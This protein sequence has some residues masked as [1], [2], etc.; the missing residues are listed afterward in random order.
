MLISRTVSL[1]ASI[2]M[3]GVTGLSVAACAARTDDVDAVETETE[4][5]AVSSSAQPDAEY[6]IVTHPDMRRCA[7]PMCG[8]YFV[9]AVNADLVTGKNAGLTKCADGSFQK[10]CHVFE[11]GYVSFGQNGRGQAAFDGKL[12]SGAAIARGASTTGSTESGVAFDKLVVRE[13]WA[14]R[15]TTPA[16]GS[17]ATLTLPDVVCQSLSCA[18]G[19]RDLVDNASGPTAIQKI[20]WAAGFTK[21]DKAEADAAGHKGGRGLLTAGTVTRSGSVRTLKISQ[22]YTRVDANVGAV[23]DTCGTRGAT[24]CAADLYCAFPAGSHCGAADGGGTCAAPSGRFCT[25]QYQPVCGCDGKT[26]G[27]ACTAAAIGVSVDFAGECAPPVAQL[28]E[29]CGGNR[30]TGPMTCAEGLFCN[31]TADAICGYADASGTCAST[32]TICTKEYA[33]VCGCDGK[34]YSTECVAN[35]FG[36]AVRTKGACDAQTP[37]L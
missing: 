6:F 28:G 15:K 5:A 30:R 17:F 14:A 37:A 27:N 26:Y 2:A 34:T 3:L 19:Y 32:P 8:G 9:K 25:E 36:V 11:I 12:K 22:F 31:Y 13:A 23:G 35:S 18:R 33:P 10:E 20:E 4:S 16:T 1:A 29:S 24:E 21:A 7:S